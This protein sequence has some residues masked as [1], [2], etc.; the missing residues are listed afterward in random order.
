MSMVEDDKLKAFFEYL[1]KYFI[2]TETINRGLKKK[3]E[4][5]YNFSKNKA[6]ENGKKKIR[7][8]L[9][10]EVLGLDYN[11]KYRN[12]NRRNYNQ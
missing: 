4:T 10:I 5:C 8:K 3:N 12:N 6:L 1:W 2:T 9:S 11:D 7:V